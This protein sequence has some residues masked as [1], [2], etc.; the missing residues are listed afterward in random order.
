MFLSPRSVIQKL[1]SAK[2]K[3]ALLLLRFYQA[4][5]ASYNWI[6][7]HWKNQYKAFGQ[8][9]KI[10][11]G[12]GAILRSPYVHVS[13]FLT[14]ACKL[15]MS[16]SV[17]ASEIAVGVIPNLLGFTVGAMAIVLAFSSAPVFKVLAQDGDPKSFFISLTANLVHFMIVQAA[18]LII[19]IVGKITANNSIDTLA[20]FFL[21]YGILVTVSVGIQL[22]QT[23]RIYNAYASIDSEKRDQPGGDVN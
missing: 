20:L 19:G 12:I 15:R 1:S 3:A 22:L 5:L 4:L 18:A 16:A 7:K 2:S 10:Y 11:G 8:Y 14:I 6:L 17:T 21:F 23:A 13:V 9:F